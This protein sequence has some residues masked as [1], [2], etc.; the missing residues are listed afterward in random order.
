MTRL[1]E[2]LLELD[3]PPVDALFVYGSNPVASAPHQGKVRRG[4]E[5]EDLFTVVVEHF[6][7]DTVDYADIVL[8]ATMQPEHA[9]LHCAYGHL[10]LAWNEPAVEA[11][12]E[13]LPNS[14]IFRRLA[15]TS[16]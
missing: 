8:P 11:P 16:A 5:R 1:G 6:P 2:A 10:Y 15:A 3:D 14:E 12:G 13:C 4:L 7:T 9:D